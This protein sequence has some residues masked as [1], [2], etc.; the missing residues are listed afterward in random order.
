MSKKL[1]W[2]DQGFEDG[3]ASFADPPEN[4]KHASYK[5]YMGGYRDGERQAQQDADRAADRVDGYDRDNAG[6]SFD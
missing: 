6:E 5:N 4:P 2:Y 1:T 3:M